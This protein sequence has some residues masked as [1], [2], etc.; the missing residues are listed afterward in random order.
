[1]EEFALNQVA[2]QNA[3]QSSETADIVIIGAGIVGLCNALMYAKQGLKVVVIDNLVHNKKFN[4]KVGESLLSHSNTFLR[5]M[6]ELDDF[7]VKSQPKLGVWFIHGM[8]GEESFDDKT[9]WALSYQEDWFDH[10]PDTLQYRATFHEK[11]LVRPEAEAFQLK[12]LRKY[13]N[14]TII[15]TAFVRD[16][17]IN[18]DRPH[19]VTWVCQATRERGVVHSKWVIDSAGRGRMLARKMNHA[20]GFGD[21]FQTTAVWLHFKNVSDDVYSDIWKYT[22]K[23]GLESRREQHTCHLWGD[24]YWIWLIRLQGGRISVGVTFDQDNQ[25]KGDTPEDQFWDVINRYP[26]LT[27]ILKPENKLQFRMYKDVQYTTDTFVSDKRYGIVGDAATNTDAYYSQGLSMSLTTSF[28]ISNIVYRDITENYLDTKYINMVNHN[29]TQDWLIIR[30][31]IKDKYTSAIADNRFFILSHLLDNIILS[32][33]LNERWYITRLL[34]ET[35]CD[36]ANDSKL[37]KKLRKKLRKNLYHSTAFGMKLF[38]P[39]T[40][41]K[42]QGHLQR[43]MGERARWRVENGVHT[44]KMKLL[45]PPLPKLLKMPFIGKKKFA[46][47]SGK[48]LE[49]KHAKFFL[50]KPNDISHFPFRVIVPVLMI[51]FMWAYQYDILSTMFHKLKKRFGFSGNVQQETLEKK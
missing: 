46:D 14:A 45:W 44:P 30:N 38:K 39:E 26:I 34:S 32:T 10:M 17:K 23:S 11:Q 4:Y 16:V 33:G 21:D 8:E 25:P 50:P 12:K 35:N 40:A 24:G 31:I 42:F 28:H 9:E 7:A 2:K 43:K 15:D 1:M 27:R 49:I 13:D 29:I 47:I 5:T 41:Q 37:H 19:E 36:P 3:H 6:G 48:E 18:D 51:Q 20:K 22:Y